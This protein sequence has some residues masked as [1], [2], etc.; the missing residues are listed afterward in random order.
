VESL[1]QEQLYIMSDR[2]GLE[3]PRPRWKKLLYL[4]QPYPDNYTDQSFLSQLKRNSTV[5]KYSPRKLVEDFS[6]ILF[7]ISSLLLVVL[8]FAGIYLHGWNLMV[9]TLIISILSVFGYIVV[10][11]IEEYS[12]VKI[13]P[14]V[15]SDVFIAEETSNI[16]SFVLII[17]VL[18]VLSPVLKSLTKSTSS[19][20]IWALSFL[21]CLS[22]TVFHDYAMNISITSSDLRYKPIL[23][24]NVS[25]SNAIVLASRLTSNSQVFF[26]LLFSIQ[27]NI[28]LPYFDVC[29]RRFNLVTVHQIVFFAL[30]QTVTC[31]VYMLVGLKFVMFWIFCAF[32]IIIGMP[33][34]FLFLQRYKNELQGPWDIAKPIIN[35]T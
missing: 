35:S 24:T 8:M 16:K 22:S 2:S 13:Q 12:K 23:S 3:A 17:F 34:Y 29:I 5:A 11:Q 27:A 31:L 7:H 6:L 32:G 25:M 10:Q 33:A 18:L 28:L 20:S 1:S 4:K 26:F 14:K 9:P 19:D 30:F 15:K 21:L